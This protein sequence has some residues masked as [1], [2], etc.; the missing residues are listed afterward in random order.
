VSQGTRWT[1]LLNPLLRVIERA[2]RVSER[3]FLGFVS[4]AGNPAGQGMVA[5]CHLPLM[6]GRSWSTRQL[7]IEPYTTVYLAG[8]TMVMGSSHGLKAGDSLH[9]TG[10]AD[11]LS[12]TTRDILNM[13]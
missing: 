1:L 12:F 8:G 5:R 11:T 13:I 10:T 2:V 4:E 3:R 6:Y 7:L 9:F